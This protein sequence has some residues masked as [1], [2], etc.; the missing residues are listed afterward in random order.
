MRAAAVAM[1]T[2][3]IWAPIVVAEPRVEI[4]AVIQGE[5]SP[6]A[7]QQWNQVLAEAG[8]DRATIRSKRVNDE[9]G[10]TN[11]GGERNPVYRVTAVLS[12][13]TLV[14]PPRSR[15][16]RRDVG[17]ISKWIRDLKDNGPEVTTSAKTAF[18]L[19]PKQLEA[20]NDDL[21]SLV[22]VSTRGAAS[23]DVV[24]QLTRR[25]R[26]TLT[27]DVGAQRALASSGAIQ[28]ELRG[29]STGTALAAV[30]RPAGLVLHPRNKAGR[31]ELA[32]V[33]ST[34]RVANWPIGW[35]SKQSPGKAIPALFD[36]E[37]TQEVEVP[38]N[39]ALDELSKRI[40]TPVLLDH[41]GMAVRRIATGT[42][43]TMRAGRSH[44][45]SIFSHLLRQ[46][47]MQYEVRVDENNKPFLWLSAGR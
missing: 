43:V 21:K 4:T 1:M 31:V 8:C 25:L 47:G 42:P 14:L 36:S 22:T 45:S 32:V 10:I 16:S 44:F 27:F 28:D 30:L 18:G 5:I 46:V 35:E 34:R 26:H 13:N 20:V 2:V 15:F 40:R 41:N 29:L 37:E 39:T 23:A 9:L 38:L 24:T 6:S 33:D 19:T 3:F 12:G 7:P 17:G 11:A